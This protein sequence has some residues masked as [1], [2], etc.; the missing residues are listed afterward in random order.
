M[1][2]RNKTE[3]KV[4]VIAT[5]FTLVNRLEKVQPVK[6]QEVVATTNEESI[7]LTNMPEFKDFLLVNELI[8]YKKKYQ[9]QIS[10]GLL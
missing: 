2:A 7:E 8:S 9:V 1:R 5:I 6:K 10:T 4:L 3:I